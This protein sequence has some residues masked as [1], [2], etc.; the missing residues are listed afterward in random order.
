M[1]FLRNEREFIS[2]FIQRSISP[3]TPKSDSCLKN[4]LHQISKPYSNYIISHFLIS[5]LCLQ[6]TTY[7]SIIIIIIIVY[8]SSSLTSSSEIIVS[9]VKNM[10]FICYDHITYITHMWWDKFQ[11]SHSLYSSD[12]FLGE[13]ISISMFILALALVYVSLSRTQHS[14]RS[15]QVELS[16]M[17]EKQ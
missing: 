9:R 6:T 4:Y 5:D 17:N 16:G 8:T 12:F 10:K 11:I 2:A 14:A 3:C 13:C 7:H 1:V 15:H